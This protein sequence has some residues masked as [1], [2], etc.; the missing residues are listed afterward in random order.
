MPTD[1]DGY[2]FWELFN[3]D[4]E[5]HP[6]VV[7]AASEVSEEYAA[8]V[9]P[10]YAEASLYPEAQ[11]LVGAAA[12][13]A[14][15][16]RRG[17]VTAKSRRQFLKTA[18][19]GAILALTFEHTAG[20]YLERTGATEKLVSLIPGG[21]RINELNGD[22]IRDLRR[23]RGKTRE[24]EDL[25][26]TYPSGAPQ[27]KLID[28]VLRFDSRKAV[29]QEE[30]DFLLQLQHASDP[31]VKYFASHQLS[32]E[33]V[34]LG[35]MR[36][37]R[38][39]IEGYADDEVPSEYKLAHYVQLISCKFNTMQR[40]DFVAGTSNWDIDTELERV[41]NYLKIAPGAPPNDLNN[42]GYVNNAIE[43][44]GGLFLHGWCFHLLAEAADAPDTNYRR[45]VWSALAALFASAS[46]IDAE[47]E[48]ER[49]RNLITPISNGL[50][51][52]ALQAHHLE[53]REQRDRFLG[54]VFGLDD[55]WPPELNYPLEWGRRL[56]R[57]DHMASLAALAV[58]SLRLQGDGPQW[59]DAA[60][61]ADELVGQRLDSAPSRAVQKAI[62]NVQ[63]RRGLEQGV[64]ATFA[65]HLVPPETFGFYLI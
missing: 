52:M 56:Q 29:S 3:K 19:I 28:I 33:Y 47:L 54:T 31:S 65:T 12:A 62:Y 44:G 13:E 48:P 42:I 61:A 64:P 4:F 6:E 16:A 26:L 45:Y 43:D 36:E 39:M 14:M 7:S 21:E 32:G 37:A 41:R 34:R 17:T 23:S 2:A 59:S 49:R 20:K 40:A 38:E 5:D 58:E 1:G 60:Q 24:V 55:F 30:L 9:D 8:K 15:S 35:F 25:R 11:K 53:D 22:F 51:V 18:G 50:F 27:R 10:E 63:R 57:R 46:K